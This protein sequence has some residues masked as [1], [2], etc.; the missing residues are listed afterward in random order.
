MSKRV[1]SKTR[2]IDEDDAPEDGGL[3]FEDPYE[4]IIEES[5]DEGAGHNGMEEDGGFEMPAI[6]EEDEVDDSEAQGEVW[7]PD[8][9][10]L[11]EGEQLECDMSAYVMYHTMSVE[12][13]CLS[14]DVVP[15]DKLGVRTKFPLSATVV[16]G[17]QA[18]APGSNKLLVMRFGS[19]HKTQNDDRE[20]DSEDDGEESDDDGDATVEV[21]RIAHA[22][23]INRVRCMPQEPHIVATWS[24]TGKVHL[25][26][27]RPQIK[28][29]DAAEGKGVA[30]PVPRGYGPVM[31]FEG[32]ST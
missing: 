26:D 19:L 22:G 14:F 4:E 11:G 27:V 23:A 7:R 29:L 8:I 1:A 21:Q 16:A 18:D 28:L 30:P 3:V 12:W 13:P 32:H 9:D 2:P 5:E 6:A 24:E 15:D 31:T 25:W 20:S 17:T 10:M